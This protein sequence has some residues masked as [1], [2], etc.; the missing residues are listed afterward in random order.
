MTFLP[1]G[2]PV[3]F[4]TNGIGLYNFAP[5]NYLQ[6]PQERFLIYTGGHYDLF[7]NVQ[8]FFAGTFSHNR[9]PQQ[10]APTPFFSITNEPVDVNVDNPF[11]KPELQQIFQQLD[12]LQAQDP[13]NLPEDGVVRLFDIRRRLLEV[14]PRFNDDDVNNAFQLEFG[15]RGEID[16]HTRW[17]TYYQVGKVDESGDLPQRRLDRPAEAPA[18]G[19]AGE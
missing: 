17:E 11:L 8:L 9:V 14:G 2:T 6:V 7:D 12:A 1:D 10:L 13:F 18:A 5:P 15:A 19:E 4:G 3:P 16:A